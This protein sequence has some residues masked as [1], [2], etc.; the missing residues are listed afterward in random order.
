[1]RKL[2]PRA[3][4]AA[5]LGLLSYCLLA[6][7]LGQGGLLAS[8][9][10]RAQLERMRTNLALL[11][12]KNLELR[13]E[14]AALQADPDRARRE[15]RSL[16]YLA[17]GEYEIVVVGRERRPVSLESPGSALPAEA[18][19]GYADAGLKAA[20]LLVGLASLALGLLRAGG[21]GAA[22]ASRRLRRS[23]EEAGASRSPPRSLAS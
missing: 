12:Q 2:A 21:E 11:R 6:F 14:V 3:L 19:P 7:T 10:T 17:R 23:A 4:L 16:G 13:N 9:S 18:P 15:A 20:G 8:L 5:W 1:M 22:R